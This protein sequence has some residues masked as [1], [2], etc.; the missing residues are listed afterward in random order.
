MSNWLK[1]VWKSLH[2][3]NWPL[4]VGQPYLYVKTDGLQ[5]IS[6]GDGKCVL[7]G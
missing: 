1:E 3:H 4:V 7:K 6:C 2:A 5:K